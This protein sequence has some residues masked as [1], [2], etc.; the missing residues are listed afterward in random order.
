MDYLT[1]LPLTVLLVLGSVGA[2][3]V[4]LLDSETAER[5]V[6]FQA[7]AALAGTTAG[8]TLT[9]VSILINLVRTPLAGLD[10]VLEQEDKRRVGSVF[11]A[12]LPKLAMTTLVA[13][14]AVLLDE[15]WDKEPQQV[16]L[17]F[18]VLWL[19]TASLSAL[20]RVVWVLRRLLDLSM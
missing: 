18:V 6:F 2:I 8:L 16:W 14:S 13:L 20:A 1:A 11:L 9:S 10:K 19:A 15:I 7:V 4:L 12:V 17:D 3:P 5:R